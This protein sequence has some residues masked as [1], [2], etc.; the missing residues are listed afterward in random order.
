VSNH[1]S[2]AQRRAPKRGEKISLS[3]ESTA[4]K[5]KGIGHLNGMAI[6]VPNTA[7]GDLVE[8]QVTKRKKSYCE[9]RLVEVVEPGEHRIEP[10]CRHA[11][12]CGGCTWQHLPYEKQLEIKSQQ[13]MDHMERIGGF[14]DI[15]QRSTLPAKNAFY[16][17]NKMEY[18]FGN[19][20]WLSR[21]EIERDEYVSD[22]GIW[23]GLHAPGRFDK[24][25]NLQECHL[26]K[27][28][29]YKILD[30][31]RSYA[32]ENDIP[33]FDT[34]EDTGYLRNLVIRTSHYT[35]DLM[36]NIV[37]F[38][39]DEELISGIS[40][41]LLEEFPQIT[42]IINNINDQ[43]NPTAIGRYE[44]II[45]GPGYITDYIHPFS[46]NIHANAFFQTHT[47]QAELLYEKAIDLA[48]LDNTGL[49]FDLYC[50][51]G[52]LSL[53]LSQ[54]AQ[55]VVGIEANEVAIKNARS[56]AEFNNVDNVSFIQGDMKDKLTGKLVEQYGKPDCVF[57]DPPRAGMHPDVVQT[58]NH[59]GAPKIVYI[60]CD[61]STMARDLK[62]L[63][64]RYHINAVQPV[65]MF[66][67]TYHI[68]T[69]AALE[70]K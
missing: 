51:V 23:C 46:F 34:I 28:I 8:A 61:S 31:L 30:T 48:E 35:D 60:S 16:Y 41:V 56:N 4:F 11:K 25:L 14:S 24:I 49:I 6:F 59:L 27:P 7:P 3:I 22:R 29:S 37:T 67:Q 39:D 70:R 69:I 18:S 12:Q 44:K 62:K 65:D 58:L 40:G 55:K 15:T 20:R 50:G 9:A 2:S 64:D 66:P 17:R 5:G 68:E 47:P 13:V 52:T 63:S 32:R 33:A 42:T 53:V 1:K 10:R 36:V 57:T 19:R 45:Y 54:H 26:Q 21:E 38:Q 43:K